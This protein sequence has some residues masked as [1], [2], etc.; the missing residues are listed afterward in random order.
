MHTRDLRRAH[1]VA[2]QLEA[3]SVWIN[4]FSDMAPQGPYGGYKQSGF[5]RTGGLDGLN[6]FLQIKNI[7]IAM[8]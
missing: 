1:G 8:G 3:G 4:T 7:R 5:G 6:E 2:R